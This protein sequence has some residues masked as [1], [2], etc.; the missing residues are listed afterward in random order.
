MEVAARG[1]EEIDLPPLMKEIDGKMVPIARTRYCP[2]SHPAVVE[3]FQNQGFRLPTSDEWE[4][5]CAS[6]SRA[7][8]YW[9]N[10]IFDS[11]EPQQAHPSYNAFGLSIAND[12]FNWEFCAEPGIMRGGD[13]GI[14]YY[15]GELSMA[16][17]CASAHAHYLSEQ[18]V[19]EGV[20]YAYAR[21]VYPLT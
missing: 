13:G 4:Y 3:L 8:F 17:V 2:V 9:G 5:A 18:Y 19:N 15:G 10:G 16:L 21:R 6:G 7:L 12:P 11:S 20:H 14:S 1:P